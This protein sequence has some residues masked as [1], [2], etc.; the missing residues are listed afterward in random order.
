MNKSKDITITILYVWSKIKNHKTYTFLRKSL[1]LQIF[2]TDNFSIRTSKS[3]NI[4]LFLL[5]TRSIPFELIFLLLFPKY[6]SRRTFKSCSGPR[7]RSKS[8][9]TLCQIFRR[10]MCRWSAAINTPLCCE[11]STPEGRRKGRWWRL[12]G[13]EATRRGSSVHGRER[14]RVPKEDESEGGVCLNAWPR[15]HQLVTDA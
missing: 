7:C 13:E 15:H 10:R 4:L 1:F 2:F 12:F 3:L 5:L 14:V 8:K 6:F 11:R 9:Q